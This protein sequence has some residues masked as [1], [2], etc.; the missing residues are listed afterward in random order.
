[1]DQTSKLVLQLGWV[2][3]GKRDRNESNSPVRAE[4]RGVNKNVLIKFSNSCLKFRV[5]W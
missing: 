5:I 3:R 1:M 4:Q 2:R